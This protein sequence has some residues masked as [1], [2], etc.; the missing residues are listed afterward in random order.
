VVAAAAAAAWVAVAASTANA[1]LDG[2]LGVDLGTTTALDNEDKRLAWEEDE[3]I[4]D[5]EVDDVEEE[6]EV[7]VEVEALLIVCNAVAAW[8]EATT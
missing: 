4:G 2:N 8:A 3:E 7:A 6:V 1:N 5:D